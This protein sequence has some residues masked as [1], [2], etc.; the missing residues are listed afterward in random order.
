MRNVSEKSCKEKQNT[1]FMFNNLFFY[2][3]AV[4][5]IMWKI[6]LTGQATDDDMA[7]ANCMPD[8]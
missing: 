3:L 2:D 6:F 5:E 7:P 4:Y 8:A 1:H